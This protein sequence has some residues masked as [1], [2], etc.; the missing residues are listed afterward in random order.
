MAQASRSVT[1]NVP[2]EKLFEVIV[3]Y[4]RYPEFLPEVKKVK[5]EAGQGSIKEVTYTVDIKAKVINYTLRHTAERP[6][7]LSWTMIK[8]EMMKGNDGTWMLKAGAQPGTT[9]ATY[10]IDLKL[11]SL[12]PAFIEKALAEQSLPGLLANFKARAEKLHGGA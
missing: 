8:G 2:P 4:E 1:V 10:T 5:V 7:K 3:D 9:D 12:V 6:S 11:S